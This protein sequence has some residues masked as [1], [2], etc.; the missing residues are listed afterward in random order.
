MFL[1]QRMT[2]SNIHFE[3]AVLPP[4]G[5][6]S[7]LPVPENQ[8]ILAEKEQLR[9]KIRD[10]IARFSY[11]ALWCSVNSQ[12]G[13]NNISRSNLTKLLSAAEGFGHLQ[14][15]VFLNIPDHAK[16]HH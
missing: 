7:Q 14:R 10:T 3:N 6:L 5:P 15:D 16:Q 13:L 12:E 4:A 1:A 9:D 11:D 8:Q 2:T